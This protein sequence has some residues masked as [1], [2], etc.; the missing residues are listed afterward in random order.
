MTRRLAD[1]PDAV[2]GFLPPVR[3][4]VDHGFH[5]SPVLGRQGCV[6]LHERVHQVHDRA[7]HVELH[8]VFSS[9][10]YPH[11]PAAGVSGQVGD[12]GLGRQVASGDEVQRL[13]PLG[14]VAAFDDAQQ[15][16][17][18]G[19]R[20]V[21]AAEVNQRVRGHAGIAQPAVAVVPVADAADVFGQAGG[22]GGK[23]GAGG[24]VHERLQ[25][26]RAAAHQVGL[27]DRAGKLG[28]P[29]RPEGLGLDTAV[30][31]GDGRFSQVVGATAQLQH[32]RSGTQVDLGPGTLVDAVFDDLPGDTG[33]AQHEQVR[34]VRHFEAVAVGHQPGGEA[35]EVEP[36]REVDDCGAAARDHPDE[37]GAS[38]GELGS[39]AGAV[40]VVGDAEVLPGGL[41]DHGVAQVPL[42]CGPGATCRRNREVARGWATHEFGKHRSGVDA[43]NTQPGDAG[44]GGDDGSGALVRQQ[45]V[46]F[47]GHQA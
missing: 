18:E 23:D 24:A 20:L 22:G 8:L 14:F 44:I 3:D 33:G 2:V 1:L 25:C 34:G 32:Q 36:R 9:V 11:R 21:I 41:Q 29:R 6:A 10:A 47:D 12:V 39:A 31:F 28:C 46:V 43:G 15:P 16:V 40:E 17:Q 38:G 45:R 26:Q 27:E 7:E 42:G 35:A 4:G 30:T 19:E 5:Q 13:Q 37:V